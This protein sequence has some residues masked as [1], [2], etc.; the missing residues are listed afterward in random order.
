MPSS[1]SF[2]KQ[3]LDVTR[4]L[5]RR[6]D[7]SVIMVT[8]IENWSQCR[9]ASNPHS[10]WRIAEGNSVPRE[11]RLYG[12]LWENDPTSHWICFLTCSSQMTWWSQV[13]LSG[14]L[15]YSMIVILYIMVTFR[16]KW[17]ARWRMLPLCVLRSSVRSDQDI[18]TSTLL[19]EYGHFWLQ[20]TEMATGVIV[21]SRLQSGSL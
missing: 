13:P 20:K 18:S 2:W 19:S 3:L 12:S 17:M 6:F 14:L 10:Y 5:P 7:K 4:G 9:S 11:V 1:L 16:V 15:Q 21:K 8:D